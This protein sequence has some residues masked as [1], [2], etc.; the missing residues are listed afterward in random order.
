MPAKAEPSNYRHGW[1][2]PPSRQ[3]LERREEMRSDIEVYHY[4]K[5]GRLCDWKCFALDKNGLSEGK[6]PSEN[7]AW[8][9]AHK[10]HCGGE[11]VEVVLKPQPRQTVTEEE[12]A[13]FIQLWINDF[14]G[15]N[16]DSWSYRQLSQAILKMLRE[17]KII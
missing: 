12:L 14:I 13:K 15:R 10:E 7:D 8:T 3:Q 6:M 1:R 5:K 17:R 16:S 2:N 4:C 9:M 11:L